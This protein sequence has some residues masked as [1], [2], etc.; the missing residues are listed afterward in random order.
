NLIVTFH[1]SLFLRCAT[2]G[3]SSSLLS[4]IDCSMALSMLSL[5]TLFTSTCIPSRPTTSASLFIP[6]YCC[7]LLAFVKPSFLQMFANSLS[8]FLPFWLLFIL[9]IFLLSSLVVSVFC[10][11]YI[12]SRTFRHLNLLFFSILSMPLS[13]CQLLI[14]FAR[15]LFPHLPL[16]L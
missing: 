12:I 5:S 11:I 8:P 16:S 6:A 9:A 1:S 4:S 10:H 2:I 7:D 3:T 14:V 13:F 15:L